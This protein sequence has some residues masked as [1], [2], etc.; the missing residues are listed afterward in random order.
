MQALRRAVLP[1]SY[2]ISARPLSRARWPKD[3]WRFIEYYVTTARGYLVDNARPKQFGD[4]YLTFQK[5]VVRFWPK[6]D[7]ARCT[8]HV[9][10]RGFSRRAKI[11]KQKSASTCVA[12]PTDFATRSPYRRVGGT[13]YV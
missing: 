2:P 4:R 10:L 5:I 7:M 6:A 1:K 13:T 8:T 11:D 9:C 3:N 12:R